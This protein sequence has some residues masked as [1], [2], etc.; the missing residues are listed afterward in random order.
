M[1]LRKR[2]FL[3]CLL[4]VSFLPF[5]MAFLSSA[6]QSIHSIRVEKAR[7]GA[8]FHF[9]NQTEGD[10]KLT[11]SE[12][13]DQSYSETSYSAV[14]TIIKELELK[15]GESLTTVLQLKSAAILVAAHTEHPDYLKS[16]IVKTSMINVSKLTVITVFGDSRINSETWWGN[17]HDLNLSIAQ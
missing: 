12:V 5:N 13:I 16:D 10:V 4:T 6:E 3:F 14:H 7:A 2:F 15:P 1:S 11:V 8:I 17:A 9:A